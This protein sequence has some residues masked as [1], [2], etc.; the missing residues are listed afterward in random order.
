MPVCSKTM[1]PLRI[2]WPL[3][4]TARSHV[5]EEHVKDVAEA[6]RP[7]ASESEVAAL[8]AA[9]R[10]ETIVLRALLRVGKD[11]VRLRPLL[12]SA[13]G[14]GIARI[15]VGV[16]LQRQLPIGFLDIFR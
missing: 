11:L 4:S 16:V 10:S 7:E 2:S 12:E 8:L 6:R 15:L 3:R 13:L 9:H 14:L 5:A 1:S